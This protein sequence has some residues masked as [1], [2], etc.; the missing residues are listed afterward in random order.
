MS[1][2]Q[3]QISNEGIYHYSGREAVKH[4]FRVAAGLDSQILGETEIL[5]QVRDAYLRNAGKDSILDR[6]FERAIQVGRRVRDETGIA[7]GNVSVAGAAVSK[8]KRLLGNNKEKKILLIGT[9]KVTEAILKSLLKMNFSFIF[10]ANRSFDKAAEFA[11]RLGGRAVRFDRLSEELQDADLVISS[12]AAPHIIVKKD[13]IKA[14]AKPLII[15]DLAMPRDVDPGISAL[16]GVT[17]FNIDD[18]REEINL[19][20]ARRMVEA[21][22]AEKI[23]EEEVKKFC[24]EFELVPAAAA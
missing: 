4:F 22:F 8:V 1:N 23:V 15:F 11:R 2:D 12:T 9:G 19:N 21:V 24:A 10:M 17:L 7:R 5:G 16:P 3:C 6:L 13:Q 20:L 18:V 14:R